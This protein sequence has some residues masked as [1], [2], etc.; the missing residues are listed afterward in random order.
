MVSLALGGGLIWVR[1]RIGCC[2][3]GLGWGRWEVKESRKWKEEFVSL[4]CRHR[5]GRE[6]FLRHQASSGVHPGASPLER[7]KGY[8]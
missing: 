2:E 4:T 7:Q 3:E 8:F 5:S 1:L 6:G